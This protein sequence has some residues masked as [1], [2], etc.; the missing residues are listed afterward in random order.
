MYYTTGTVEPTNQRHGPPR[1]L[2]NFEQL[3]VLQLLLDNPNMY[4][5]KIER[6]LYGFTGTDVHI[7][8]IYRTVH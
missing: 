8:T 1:I 4:L 6:E 7:S 3:T 2:T 5:D